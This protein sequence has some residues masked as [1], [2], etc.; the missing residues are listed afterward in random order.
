MLGSLARAYENLAQLVV[1]YDLS[2]AGSVDTL[3][4]WRAESVRKKARFFQL[5]R[6]PLR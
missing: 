6:V 1:R 2:C 3:Y 4:V 5:K